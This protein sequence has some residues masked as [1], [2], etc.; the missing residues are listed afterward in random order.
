MNSSYTRC[1][2]AIE[3]SKIKVAIADVGI[4][5]SY[6]GQPL[7]NEVSSFM[8]KMGYHVYNMCGFHETPIRQTVVKNFVFMSG[9]FRHELRKKLGDVCGW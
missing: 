2:T 5:E 8:S 7:F 4:L 9:S 6:T 3:Q 1:K